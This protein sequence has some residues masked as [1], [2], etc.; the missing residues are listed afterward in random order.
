MSLYFEYPTDLPEKEDAIVSCLAWSNGDHP[1]MSVAYK[2]GAQSFVLMCHEEGEPIDKPM[3][4]KRD[5]SCTMMCW[6][7]RSAI[8]AMGWD[9]GAV[10]SW[11]DQE[12]ILREDVKTHKAPITY[13]SWSPEGSRLITGDQLGVL[14]VWQCD[15]RGRLEWKHRY[16]KKGAITHCVFRAV[17]SAFMSEEVGCPPFFFGGA[18]SMLYFGD[19]MGRCSDVVNL[20][21]PVNGMFYSHKHDYLVIVTRDVIMY[22]YNLDA[23]MSLDKKVKL[24]IKGDGAEL[25]CIWAGSNLLAAANNEDCVRFWH[26]TKDDN[27]VLTLQDHKHSVGSNEAIKHVA[28][29]PR[30]RTLAGWCASG[31]VV[32]WSFLGESMNGKDP[33][34][35]DWEVL[36]SVETTTTGPDIK[37][38]WGPGNGLLGVGSKNVASVLNRTELHCKTAAQNSIIQLSADTVLIST[39]NGHSC[40]VQTSIR[41]KGVDLNDQYCVMWNGKKAEV[42]ELESGKMTTHSMFASKARIC[43]LKGE[44]IYCISGHRLEICNLGGVVKKSVSFSEEEGTPL[45]LDINKDHLVM[46]TSIGTVKLWDISRAEPRAVVPGRVFDEFVSVFKSIKV[47]CNGTKVSILAQHDDH[48]G[49]L[50]PDSKLYVYDVELDRVFPYDFGPFYYPVHHHWDATESKLLAIETKKFDGGSDEFGEE[51]PSLVDEEENEA[52][53]SSA[54]YSGL[55]TTTLFCTSEY[56]VLLQDSFAVPKGQLL[57]GLEVPHLYFMARSDKPGH[58]GAPRV[59]RRVLRDFVGLESVDEETKNDL[60]NFSYFLTVG[61]MDEAYRAVK[62]IKSDTIWEKMAE[63]CVK[64][65]RLD[66][67]EVCLGNMGNARG[68]RAVR[69]A[70]LR[71]PEREAQVAMVAIQLNLL[72]DAER[73][74]KECNRWDL[75]VKLYQACGRWKDAIKVCEKHDRIHL[76]TTCYLYAKH[77]EAIGE[78]KE[79]I[80]YYELSDTHTHEVPRMLFNPEQIGDLEHY[81]KSS[82]VKGLLKWWAQYCES[83]GQYN[84][85]IIYYTQA[86]ETLSLVRVHCYQGEE[87]QATE[88]CNTTNDPAACY[89]LA[90][91]LEK[92]DRIKEAIK[93]YTKAFRFNH[94]VR[95]AKEH[96]MDQELL[97]LALESSSTA[98]KLD[99]AQCFEDKGQMDKAVL[100]YQKGGQNNKALDLSFKHNL[101]ESLAII[102]DN[103][104]SDT[105][106]AL[107]ARCGE[108]FMEHGQYDKAVHLFITGKKATQALEMCLLHNV[109]IDEK[110]AEFLTPSKDSDENYRLEVLL[111]LANLCRDQGNYHLA[112]KKFTQAGDKIQA[113]KCLLKSAD[114]EKIIYYAS[115]AKKKEIYILS[116]NYLQ[117]L[118]WHNDQEIMKKI[119]DFYTKAKATAQLAAFHDACAQVEIDEFRDYEKALGAL[120]E[121]LKFI[122]TAKDLA[123]KEMR[124]EALD[125]RI[126]LVERFVEARKLEKRNPAEM[127]KLCYALLDQPDLDASVRVGD[128]YALLIEHYHSQN[129]FKEAHEVMKRMK[130]ENIP[131]NPYIDQ[132]VISKIVK[133]MGGDRAFAREQPP[134]RGGKGL[135]EDLEEEYDDR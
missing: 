25:Q 89:H 114:T 40:K 81:I 100:L 97:T 95:L 83:N 56:G 22:K 27:Y 125:Q 133:A 15:A 84:D 91:Q 46:S 68:A 28:F 128:I 11:T 34:S 93:Y 61:N 10:C 7:P 13:L 45:L 106:P 12:R 85:A 26:L 38:S 116:A 79:A 31:R 53:R 111:K 1:I 119:I 127:I 50:V 14:S 41:V 113:M 70:K 48:S 108:F 112:C 55:E 121:A 54:A 4:I 5:G 94:G 131:L 30:T 39:K 130:R 107:L 72:A 63:V 69:E 86:K 77:L 73:L 126:R 87:D 71:E 103:L 90:G 47:N 49:V 96:S 78:T 32:M 9:D 104:G 67:A 21:G 66:V 120:K 92:Q 44:T 36:P 75:L 18:S 37:M 24:S 82:K 132:G 35:E 57:I 62:K 98:I 109:P 3:E 52:L 117:N 16:Q 59:K 105:D 33:S 80:K 2:E 58:E 74:Y 51:D 135:D 76:K 29:N 102:S 60:I 122:I 134:Q 124:L 129:Q 43:A 64:A 110:M 8:L 20:G 88:L 65:K 19:D 99:A 101:F 23:K 115:M 6:H 17:S 42:R 123:D 118:N